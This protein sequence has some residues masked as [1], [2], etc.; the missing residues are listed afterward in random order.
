MISGPASQASSSLRFILF[1]LEFVAHLLRARRRCF[2]DVPQRS[3]RCACFRGAAFAYVGVGLCNVCML[4]TPRILYPR[5]A[6][7]FNLLITNALSGHYVLRASVLK[8]LKIHIGKL[9]G[10][11]F[12]YTCTYIVLVHLLYVFHPPSNQRLRD[13]VT[14][15]RVASTLVQF[16]LD[17]LIIFAE[18]F[19]IP[20]MGY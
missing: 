18:V 19:R 2:H 7:L 5:E 15:Q 10:L 12:E 8:F 3:P 20:R 4:A 1:V 9:H 6:F 14:Y 13:V 17:S 16:P 11:C